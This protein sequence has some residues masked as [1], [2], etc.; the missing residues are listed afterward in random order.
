M[1]IF[2]KLA[3]FANK[4]KLL[5]NTVRNCPEVCNWRQNTLRSSHFA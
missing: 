3:T 5:Q 1:L 4:L 2:L